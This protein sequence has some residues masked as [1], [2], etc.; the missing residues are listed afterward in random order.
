MVQKRIF[1]PPSP[2]Q[3]YPVSQIEDALRQ[4]Q[5]RVSGKTTITYGADDK[6]KV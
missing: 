6:V 5:N 4:F 2:L 3:V 1:L